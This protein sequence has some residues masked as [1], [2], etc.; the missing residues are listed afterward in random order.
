MST[1]TIT[2]KRQVSIPQKIMDI[3]GVKE[4]DKISYILDADNQVKVANPVD[5]I[6]KA[7]GSVKLP[8]RFKGMPLEDIIEQAKL[9]YYQEEILN[10]KNQV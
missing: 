5:L 2:K 7:R 9:E 1:Y 4:G 10:K 8:E 6:R 3:L